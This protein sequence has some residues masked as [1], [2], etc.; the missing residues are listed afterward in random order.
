MLDIGFME[1]FVIGALALIVV[2]PKDLPGLLRTVGQ[3]VAKARGMAREFQ[4]TMEDAA[5]EADLGDVADMVKG[6]GNLNKLPFDNQIVD[7][8]KEF[9][10]SVKAGVDGAK[11]EF[12]KPDGETPKID[13][14]SPSATAE[15]SSAAG[16]GGAKPDPA[17]PK[18][19]PEP[20]KDASASAPKKP[21]AKKP[22]ARKPAAKKPAV[23]KPA[24]KKPAASKATAART[25][26]TKTATAK[27]KTA[28]KPKTTPEKSA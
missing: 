11:T 7:S 18:A 13:P 28:A 19:K 6:K 25:T 14:A 26:T 15:E 10:R 23:K 9:E 16:T 12:E 21:A 4:H 8:M 20:A 1:I 3:F 24:A 2:G 5:R 17:A 27:P 22:A